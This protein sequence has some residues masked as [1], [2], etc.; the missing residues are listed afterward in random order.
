MKAYEIC[1]TENGKSLSD[2]TFANTEKEA[3]NKMINSDTLF[4][5]YEPTNSYGMKIRR[6][7]PL[8]DKESLSTMK[9]VEILVDKCGWYWELKGNQYEHSN[10]SKMQ[11]ERDWINQYGAEL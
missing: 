6:I 8:D 9:K 2:V 1:Y 11:F 10:F 7:K 4:Q 5:N 3:K